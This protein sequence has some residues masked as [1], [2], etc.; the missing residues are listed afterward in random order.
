MLSCSAA[1]IDYSCLAGYEVNGINSRK[2]YVY[3]LAA[4]IEADL[5]SIASARSPCT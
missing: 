3:V 2:R 1:T 4:G 5:S